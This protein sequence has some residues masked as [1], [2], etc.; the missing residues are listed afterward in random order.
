MACEDW[1]HVGQDKVQWPGLVKTDE[2]SGF[3]EEGEFLYQLRN[4]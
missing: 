2:T 1:I 3:I 4:W